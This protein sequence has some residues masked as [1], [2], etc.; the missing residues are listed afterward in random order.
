VA[1]APARWRSSITSRNE[2]D[3]LGL[4]VDLWPIDLDATAPRPVIPGKR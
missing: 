4:A 1:A 3:D 2:L